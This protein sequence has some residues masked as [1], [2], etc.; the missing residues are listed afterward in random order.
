M[1]L[2]AAL[3]V[4]RWLEILLTG[5]GNILRINKSEVTRRL[6]TVGLL[7]IQVPL[8]FSVVGEGLLRDSPNWQ[9]TAPG[10]SGFPDGP[11]EW[12][13]VS[14]TNVFTLGNRYRRVPQPSE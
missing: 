13:Y 12:L 2:F 10:A 6:L 9:G 11:M 7:G 14:W 8:I 4:W 3:A 1:A 5:I